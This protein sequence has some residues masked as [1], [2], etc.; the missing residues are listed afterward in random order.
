MKA[1]GLLAKYLS[2]NYHLVLLV[3]G[4]SAVAL[5]Q[6]LISGGEW[7]TIATATIAAFRAG[8]AVVEWIHKQGERNEPPQ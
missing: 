6:K 3:I 5:F 7:A 8:D 2:R 4:I 1:T